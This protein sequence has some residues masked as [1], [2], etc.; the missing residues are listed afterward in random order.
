MPASEFP[1]FEPFPGLTSPWA[2]TLAGRFWPQQTKLKEDHFI[3]IA[4]TA[5]DRLLVAE[6]SN[7]QQCSSPHALF[8]ML[9]GLTG[10]Y[11]SKYMI[12]L[13]QKLLARYQRTCVWRVNLRNCGPGFGYSR[14]IYHSGRSD[15]LAAIVAKAITTFP[16]TEIYLIGV[17]LGGNITLKYLGESGAAIA[18]QVKG[19]ISVS[20]P[21]DLARSARHLSRPENAF[22]DK[23]FVREVMN[24][25]RRLH[26]KFP[27]LPYG[28]FAHPPARLTDLDDVYTAPRG[29]FTDAADYYEKSS[30]LRL[31]PSIQVPTLHICSD[32]DPVVFAPAYHELR[33]ILEPTRLHTFAFAKHGGHVGFIGAPGRSSIRWM[34]AVVLRWLDSLNHKKI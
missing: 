10:C 28:N 26:E 11:Q 3:E 33:D 12:R 1:L 13:S 15:D 8:I 22:F 20:A 29:G 18:P 30:S 34:D 27:D 17:S 24:E 9:H 23:Y 7:I 21:I 2:Q 16:N 14:G 6:N 32:D 5:G 19:A 4:L 25:I 31:I